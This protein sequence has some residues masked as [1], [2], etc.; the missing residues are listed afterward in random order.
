VRFINF[1]A[2]KLFNARR[3]LRRY[4]IRV[5]RYYPLLIKTYGVECKSN[6][7]GLLYAALELEWGFIRAITPFYSVYDLSPISTS[8]AKIKADKSKA[9]STI[10]AYWSPKGGGYQVSDRDR[11]GRRQ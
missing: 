7:L 5:C 1:G 9:A 3:L 10:R 6:V 8:L 2:V 11:L 4:D